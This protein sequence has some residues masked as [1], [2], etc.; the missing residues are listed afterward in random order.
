MQIKE[1]HQL[2]AKVGSHLDSSAPSEFDLDNMNLTSEDMR[3]V[4][5]RSYVKGDTM[6]GHPMVPKLDLNVVAEAK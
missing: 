6:K 2:K 4:D 5:Q 3:P 1:I